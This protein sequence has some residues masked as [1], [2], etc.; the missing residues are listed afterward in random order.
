MDR[1][2]KLLIPFKDIEKRQITVLISLLK[3]AVEIA[4]RLMVVEYKDK[5]KRMSHGGF[6]GLSHL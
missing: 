6:S 3:Y 2:S 1:D 5:S 4:H